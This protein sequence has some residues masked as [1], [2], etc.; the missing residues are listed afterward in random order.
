MVHACTLNLTVVRILTLDE[1]ELLHL[2]Q[3]C[4]L[5]TYTA[6]ALMSAW[7]ARGQRIGALLAAF[8]LTLA[9]LPTELTLEG[10]ANETGWCP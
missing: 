8:F 9:A 1:T 5:P 6:M 7:T 4:L 3:R 2:A 10:T